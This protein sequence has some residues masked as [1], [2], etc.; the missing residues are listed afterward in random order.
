MKLTDAT[1][2]ALSHPDGQKDYS[3]HLVRGL[4]LRVGKQTNSLFRK[5]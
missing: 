1:I 4:L 2:R 3:D 5:S